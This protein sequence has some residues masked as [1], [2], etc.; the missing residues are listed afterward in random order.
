M[1]VDF[2]CQHCRSVQRVPPSRAKGR[3]YCSHK[4]RRDATLASPECAKA[5]EMYAAGKSLRRVMAETGINR[6]TLRSFMHGNR[7]ERRPRIYATALSV[8]E[9][10]LKMV[11]INA[12]TG[13][14]DVP[15]L[16]EFGYGMLSVNGKPDVAHRWSWRVYRG[17]I[18]KGKM[19][20]HHCDNP[21]CINPDHL[22]LGTQKDN[23]SDAARKGRLGKRRAA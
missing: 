8:E 17:E 11:S 16:H 15:A 4:C 22:F 14:W 12:D 1:S 9:R 6:E 3:V 7:M 13:C 19:I 2:V 21:S 20:C 5:A 23:M 10:L 18:P